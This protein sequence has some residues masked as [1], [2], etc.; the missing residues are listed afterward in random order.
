VAISLKGMPTTILEPVGQ[1]EGMVSEETRY[2]G[3]DRK[4]NVVHVLLSGT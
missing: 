2:A 3:L 4:Y 1:E